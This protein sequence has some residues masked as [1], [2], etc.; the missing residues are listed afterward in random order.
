MIDEK[1]IK[2]AAEQHALD[3]DLADNLKN[4]I[5]QGIISVAKEKSFRDGAKWAL[6]QSQWIAIT[7]QMPDECL[8][9]LVFIPE[10]DHI[11]TAVYEKKEGWYATY[12]GI[13]ITSPVTHWMSLPEPPKQ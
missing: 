4:L 8:P 7:E 12:E 1:K 3:M 13:S 5:D 10:Q 9:V 6:E 11:N 2:L